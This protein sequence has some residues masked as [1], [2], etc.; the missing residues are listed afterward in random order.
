M[1]KEKKEMVLKAINELKPTDKKED[2][3]K[4]VGDEL[5]Q[6]EADIIFEAYKKGCYEYNTKLWTMETK[7]QKL[8]LAIADNM[9]KN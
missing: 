8:A 1:E 6:D 4:K 7:Y 5:S 9:I 3:Y 2:F